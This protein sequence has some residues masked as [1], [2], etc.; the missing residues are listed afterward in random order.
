LYPG[1]ALVISGPF[2]ETSKHGNKIEET[3]MFELAFN[4][5]VASTT[6]VT[7]TNNWPIVHART[8][9]ARFTREKQQGPYYQEGPD[10][11]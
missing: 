11:L 4:F 5:Q 3:G 9:K 2:Y 6:P 7:A 1:T 8:A 10:H